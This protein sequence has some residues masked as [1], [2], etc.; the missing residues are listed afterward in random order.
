MIGQSEVFLKAVQLILKI[1]SCDAP[2][3]I[4]GE[5]GTGKELA[6]RAIHY[7]GLRPAHPFVPVN[8]GAIP[9]LLI[10]NELYGHRK[11]AFTDAR[12]DHSGL[13]AHAQSGTLFL[14]E[15]SALTPRGQVALLRFLQDQRYRP[16]GSKQERQADVRI[17]AASNSNLTDLVDSGQFRDDLFYRLKILSVEI[18][19]LRERKGD[20]ELL[21]KHFVQLGSKRFGKPSIQFH[22]DTVDWFACYRWPGN[23]RELENLVYRALLLAEELVVAIPPL[24]Q[25]RIERRKRTDRRS[26]IGEHLTYRQAKARAI[27]D[28]EKKYLSSLMA[29]CSGNVTEAAK[30]AGT[31]R[32]HL[33]KLLKKFQIDNKKIRTHVM[34]EQET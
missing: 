24:S 23:V 30:R 14:D 15:I 17:I 34:G 19:P 12:E 26:F 5:T 13:I 2:V 1:A 8:C 25:C 4:E 7:Q 29:E 32:R 21:A 10:E 11:G 6:A 28:F 3:L 22:S 20:A 16:V 27:E 33:G 18:P 31:E 9:D